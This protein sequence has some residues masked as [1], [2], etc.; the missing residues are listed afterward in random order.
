MPLVA[1]ER[2][3]IRA[4]RARGGG[5]HQFERI[6]IFLLRHQARAGG[7]RVAEPRVA[8]RRRRPQHEL[9]AGARRRNDGARRG[10]QAGRARRRDRRPC[11]ARCATVRRSPVRAPPRRGRAAATSR[12]ARPNRADRSAPRPRATRAKAPRRAHE[13]L[14][15]GVEPK[16]QRHRLRRLPMRRCRQQ[17]AVLERGGRAHLRRRWRDRERQR[18]AAFGPIARVE[19]QRGRDLIVAA[20]AGVQ[21]RTGDPV[22]VRARVRR[23][24]RGRPRTSPAARERD[25]RAV[26]DLTRRRRR[27]RRAVRRAATPTSSPPSASAV[28][29][30]R[31]QRTSNGASTRSSSSEEPKASSAASGAPAKPS[32]PLQRRPASARLLG[33]GRSRSVRRASTAARPRRLS[34]HPRRSAGPRSR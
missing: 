14:R 5:P 18:R 19:Q 27:A 33:H 26:G 4:E 17:R 28:T 22:R 11:R 2:A 10:M 20:A 13:A 21:R 32:A 3:G 34:R 24:R 15:G 23:S 31:E 16:R 9:F 7:G 6:G 30:A 25:E 8:E 12:P 1:R 29:C